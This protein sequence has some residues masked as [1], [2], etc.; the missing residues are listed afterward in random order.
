MLTENDRAS[1]NIH[2]QFETEHGTRLLKR[3][4]SDGIDARWRDNGVDVRAES[5]ASLLKVAWHES[6]RRIIVS[7]RWEYKHAWR[8]KR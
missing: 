2:S 8:Q 7:S 1:I 5:L 6:S 3:W 4:Q